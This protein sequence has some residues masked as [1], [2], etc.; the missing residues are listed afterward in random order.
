MA[1]N[2]ESPAADV[3]FDVGPVR[4]AAKWLL[5]AF[6]AVG[7]VILGGVQFSAIGEL[8]GDRLVYA[9]AGFGLALT[10]VGLAIWWTSTV[11]VTR[12]VSVTALRTDA[13]AVRFI[14]EQKDIVG[15]EFKSLQAFMTER[16][17]AWDAWNAG[18]TDL[19]SKLTHLEKTATRIARIWRY[20]K[21]CRTFTWARRFA[22]VGATLVGIGVVVFTYATR[23]ADERWVAKN[24][25]AV[26]VSYHLRQAARSELLNHVQPQC[27]PSSGS[28]TLLDGWPGGSDLLIAS[29]APACSPL[30]L[31]WSSE[32]GVLAAQAATAPV[33]SPAPPP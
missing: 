29:A 32:L 11:L 15:Y 9:L 2:E 27:I 3:S 17:D 7:A 20:E 30:R 12:I 5:T 6:A 26:T 33:V 16:K 8:T 4:E 31:H 25:A 21:V 1:A 10:G 23:N 28:A 19:A 24:P 13:K 14:N 22:F 18:Q